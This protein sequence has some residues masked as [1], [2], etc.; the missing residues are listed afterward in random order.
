M[1]VSEGSLLASEALRV[2]FTK[3]HAAD[4]AQA[5]CT[6]SSSC[7]QWSGIWH[8]EALLQACVLSVHSGPRCIVQ[9]QEALLNGSS[10][11]ERQRRKAALLCVA[12]HASC[13]E[14]R[15]PFP[16]EHSSLGRHPPWSTNRDR[17]T[18]LPSDVNSTTQHGKQATTAGA[19]TM[20]L[21]EAA[22]LHSSKQQVAPASSTPHLSPFPRTGTHMRV[23]RQGYM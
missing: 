18:S 5:Y 4:G 16:H 15:R 19:R 17:Q 7:R 2:H 12:R 10:S 20:T 21:A 6:F 1:V 13:T 14:L 8:G 3:L 23:Y 22:H 9:S 11:G